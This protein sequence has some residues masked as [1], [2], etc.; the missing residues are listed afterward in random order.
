MNWCVVSTP[1]SASWPRATFQVPLPRESPVLRWQLSSTRT[2]ATLARSRGRDSSTSLSESSVGFGFRG[3]N[4]ARPYVSSNILKQSEWCVLRTVVRC[5]LAL[6][7]VNSVD[8]RCAR[9]FSRCNMQSQCDKEPFVHLRLIRSIPS[10]CK[11]LSYHFQV[12]EC[13]FEFEHRWVFRCLLPCARLLS[14]HRVH[15][16]L[17]RMCQGRRQRCHGKEKEAGRTALPRGERTVST[18]QSQTSVS[19]T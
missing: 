14:P 1:Q 12:R 13:S 16:W 7:H 17:D 4:T 11:W 19:W 9:V 10:P 3:R 2:T 15:V 6:L 5:E 8:G 18:T